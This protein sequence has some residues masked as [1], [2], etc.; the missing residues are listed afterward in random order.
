MNKRILRNF[1]RSTVLLS[2]SIMSLTWTNNKANATTLSEKNAAKY[3]FYFIGDGMAAPQINL[4]EAALNENNFSDHINSES[5]SIG[6]GKLRMREL[7]ITGMATTH[8]YDRYITDSAAAGTALATG[9]KTDCGVIGQ[10]PSGTKLK[11]IAYMAKEKGMKVGIVSSVSID[12]A[13]PAAFY[14]N[15]ISRNNYKE[16]S[17]QLLTS[18]FDYFA[19][20]SV[21][22]DKRASVEKTSPKVAYQNYIKKATEKG[23]TCVSTK[24]DFDKLVNGDKAI[25]TI[26][27]LA[28]EQYV[29]DGSA[30]P[31]AM[32]L[33]R[34]ENVNNKISI[35]DFTAKGIELLSNDNG[36]FMMVE[37]GKIDWACHANDAAATA[38]DVIAFDEAIG[39][40][41]DFAKNHPDETL[42]VITGDHDCGGLTLGFAGT[43]YDSAFELL[44]N[45]K[46]SF[47]SFTLEVNKMVK[48][49]AS[50]EEMLAYTCNIFGFTNDVTDG[51]EAVINR[52]TELSDYEIKMLKDAYNKSY[53]NIARNEYEDEFQYMGGFG[54]YDPYTVTCN[55]ILN[56]KSGID[57]TSYSHT[58]VPVPVFAKGANQELFVGYYDNTNIPKLIMKAANLK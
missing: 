11:S 27:L 3:I 55:H 8:A 6:I 42:I 20:G 44:G 26:E 36:F 58:A 25:A 19:G 22:W 46:M 48:R 7:P 4:A 16:I 52:T 53:N 54:G 38:H 45:Q 24:E 2:I 14:A 29:G 28:D 47:Q 41:L 17:D 33:D 21:K 5:K 32:D 23:Y 35:A 51:S 37:S 30:L 1:K 40:A 56:N 49:K 43:A 57:Y 13:T 10:A 39:V 34:E 18:G 31:Y 12:H 50:F 15:N 9:E